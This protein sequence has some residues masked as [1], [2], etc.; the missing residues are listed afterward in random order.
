MNRDNLLGKIRALLSKTAENGCSEAEAMAALDKAR[1]MMDAYEVTEDDLALTKAEKA[2]FRTE[3]D[4]T[5]DAH[6]IKR[7]L[8]SAVA[9][10]CDCRA[11]RGHSGALTFC[12][13]PSDAQFATWLLDNL[14]RFVQAELVNHL[15]GSLAGRGERRLVITGFV[16][17]CTARISERLAAL[18]KQSETVATNNGRALIVVK[19]SAIADAMASKGI[20][21]GKSRRSSRRMDAGAYRAGQSAGDGASFGRPIGGRSGALRIGN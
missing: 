5:R 20:R 7:Y 9:K 3:P 8:A 4:G 12:G 17:E 2:V 6:D 18:C 14:T 16:M 1:A 15:R 19:S 11:W 21:L 13:L 10:F